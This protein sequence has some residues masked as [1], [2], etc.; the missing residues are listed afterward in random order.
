M[1]NNNILI[2]NP[3]KYSRTKNT[4]KNFKQKKTFLELLYK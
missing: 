3:N 4:E 2:C 1:K